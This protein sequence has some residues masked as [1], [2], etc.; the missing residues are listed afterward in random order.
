MLR[1][2]IAPFIRTRN[3]VFACII[4]GLLLQGS[5]QMKPDK[6][7]IFGGSLLLS[8]MDVVFV[9]LE[10]VVWIFAVSFSSW[11]EED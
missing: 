6:Q 11:C 2:V 4:E 3:D 7:R 8:W 9:A 1:G 10:L 5:L